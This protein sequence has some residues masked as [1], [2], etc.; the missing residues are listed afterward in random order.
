MPAATFKGKA[1]LVPMSISFIGAEFVEKA[2]ELDT[3][4]VQQAD[5][6]PLGN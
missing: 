3:N 6:Y 5:Y 1:S 2:Q 4:I